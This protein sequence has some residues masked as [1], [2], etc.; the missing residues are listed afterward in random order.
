MDGPS[1]GEGPTKARGGVARRSKQV[2]MRG[3][4]QVED[5]HQQRNKRTR[6][7]PSSRRPPLDD[8]RKK[9]SRVYTLAWEALRPLT[10]RG[11]KTARG[12]SALN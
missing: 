9:S 6:R 4:Q 11:S 3:L 7:P 8:T 5:E 1:G 12:S 2:S 10:Q